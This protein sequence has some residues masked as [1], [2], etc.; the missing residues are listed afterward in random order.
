MQDF[1]SKDLKAAKA[2]ERSDP[3]AA[4][5]SQEGLKRNQDIT[6]GNIDIQTEAATAP[7]KG[8]KAAADLTNAQLKNLLDMQ[9]NA[10]DELK[11]FE[12]LDEVKTYRQGMRYFSAALGVPTGGEGDQDLITLAAKVQ[13]PTGA[14]MQ[15]DIDRYNN[16]QVAKD[17]LPQWALNQ[18]N[19]SGKFT[20]ETRKKIIAFMRNR[21]ETYR[22]PYQDMRKSFE[23]RAAFLNEQLVPL[24]IKPI[25]VD[26][27]L[28]SDPL[29]LYK[30]KIDAYDRQV[31]VDRVRAERETGGPS[32]DILAGVPEGAQ[33]A[34]QDIQGWRFSPETEVDLNAISTSPTGTPE[35]FAKL[36]A[37]R[38]VSEGH[39]PPSQRDD[40][41][42]QA[43]LDNQDF[44]K[45]TPEQRKTPIAIDY[46]EVDKAASENAGLLDTVAQSGRNLPE[47]GMQLLEGATAL[48]KDVVLS[49]LTGERS[50][51]VKTFTDLAAELGQGQFDGPTITAMA[52][53]MKERYGSMDAIQRTLIK[54]P[55]GLAADM[56]IFVTG[57]GSALARAPGA[58]GKFGEGVATAG[59][60]M[61]P[62]SAA[63]G[64]VT[65]GLPA[66]YNAA[67]TRAPG[68]TQGFENLPS[69]IAA[70]PSGVGGQSLREATS[71]GFERGAQG[72][73]PRSEAFTTAMRGEVDGAEL[74]TTAR[75]AVDKIREKA[76]DAYRAGM[77]QFGRVPTP[78]SIDNVRL[79]MANIKPKS[80]D[81]W[82][83]RKGPRPPEHLAWEQMND[84]VEE[85]AQK[86]AND[87]NL[88][89]PLELDQFKQDMFEIGSKVG[90]QYDR[91]ASRI[92]GTAY[93]A[94]RQE[95]VKHDRI[96]AKTMKDY[97]TAIKQAQQIETE[98]GLSAARG[99][100]PN[101]ASA[102]RKLQAAVGRNN[103]NTNYGQRAEQ[104]NI[105][106][107][108]DPDGTIIPTL[109]G[110]N[111]NTFRPRGLNAAVT[112]GAGI[113]AAYTNP[114]TLLAAPAFM[115]RVVGE[116][117]YGTGVAAGFGKRG[118]DAVT[119]SPLGKRLADTG[120][121]LAGL[122]DKYPQLFL[123]E[124]QLGT[125]LQET[126][127]ERLERMYAGAMPSI[128]ANASYEGYVPPETTQQAAPAM[129]APAAPTVTLGDMAAGQAAEPAALPADAGALID[130]RTGRE[131]YLD[132]ESNEYKDALTG[133]VVKGYQ[134]MYRGGAVQRFKNGGS[135]GYD[136]A[137][138]ARTFGQGLTFGFGDEIEAK[139][140]TLAAKDPK[141]YEAAL[142]RIRAGQQGYAEANPMTSGGLEMAGM[143]GGA[144]LTPSLAALRVPGAV[145][146]VAARAPRLSKFGVDLVEDGLQGAAY[147]AGKAEP[148]RGK[149]E[150]SRMQAVRDDTPQNALTYMEMSALG[151]LGKEGLKRGVSTKPG[152]QAALAARNFAQN[153]FAILRRR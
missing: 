37:D 42:Q 93:N 133:E 87:P 52:E 68:F 84:F 23:G 62:L 67:K 20:P 99:K 135:T 56:S 152:Y 122:Y 40:Y 113:P 149:P 141:A 10:R 98:L 22:L 57:G 97:E 83:D 9:T 19:N 90:G 81:T 28:G 61:D 79:R 126:E 132:P 63:T 77:A 55:L 127:Q 96:Y 150:T 54:D 1:W 72:V 64:L 120:S 139:L 106:N 7:Y 73:T 27:I 130:K 123:A 30:P 46:R 18:W 112:L 74:I 95:L 115:P 104:V 111:V 103:A 80:Y 71:A 32:A 107:E 134:G 129:V 100:S 143:V 66:A 116:L 138:A 58:V 15:G 6:K 44:F 137:N 85:Y 25:P 131:I 124:A 36:L 148:V 86:A 144:M 11:T 21:I 119:G 153:P 39:V 49:A 94:V 12:G 110:S 48:P 4:K 75:T 16:V 88:L 13:D 108:L 34:G 136:Y 26:Q 31:E 50:G 151:K 45:Q 3:T 65:E 101:V 2:E 114:L 53:A 60:I 35:A 69:E 102:T 142:K 14:V 82:S 17:Y 29:T 89:L 47:S 128:P 118:L 41:Y 105:L 92:A 70:F 76:S 78:L 43:L 140:R 59:K 109:A 117:A 24:G 147:S 8:P 145:S 5:R 38:A 51:S 121:D 146:R 125:K 91:K 33:I